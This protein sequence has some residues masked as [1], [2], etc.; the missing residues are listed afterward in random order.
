MDVEMQ[1]LLQNLENSETVS[2]AGYDFHTGE[3]GG[4]SVV[5]I[6]CGVGKVN[7]ARGTQMLI[8]RFDPEAVINSGIAGGTAAG[9]HVG[10]IIVGTDFVQHDFDVTAFGHVKGYLCTGERDDRPTVFYSDIQL[11]EELIRAAKTAAP[12]RDVRE[13]RIA[14]G[15]QFVS[16]EEKK[17]EI[18]AEFGAV[19]AEMEGASIAQTCAY[20]GVPFAVLRVI[21]D[22][23]DGTAP[24]NYDQ[25]E[26]SS[27]DL[28]AAVIRQ[29]V[30][31]HLD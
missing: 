19:C 17:E 25:F 22:L 14:S 2:A 29:F 27:A 9:L 8:D 20:A 18:A 23:A 10:D 12:E 16:T 1:D 15:D 13:G 31:N 3:M 4:A 24:E 7:A 26:K 11:I 5:L 21:S 6:R 30:R 28:S